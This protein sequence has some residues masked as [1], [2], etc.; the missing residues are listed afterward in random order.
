ME[1]RKK[2]MW[3]STAFRKKCGRFIAYIYVFFI[4]LNKRL[5]VKGKKRLAVSFC[6]CIVAGIIAFSLLGGNETKTAL[7]KSSMDITLTDNHNRVTGGQTG[8]SIELNRS[9]VTGSKKQASDAQTDNKINGVSKKNIDTKKNTDMNTGLRNHVV[10]ANE[11]ED[12]SGK[13]P[14]QVEEQPEMLSPVQALLKNN[15]EKRQ[16][17]TVEAKIRYQ[18]P[19]QPGYDEKQNYDGVQSA[20]DYIKRVV[21]HIDEKTKEEEE[22]QTKQEG[23]SVD[24]N[25]VDDVDEKS[26][27]EGT[28]TPEASSEPVK[29]EKELPSTE[30]S[31]EDSLYDDVTADNR[32]FTVSG[33]RRSS[34]GENV[35]DGDI[36]IKPTGFNGFDR[37]RLGEEGEFVSELAL[38]KEVVGE[39]ITLYFSVR[40]ME[41]LLRL[42][43]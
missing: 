41:S 1:E 21:Y 15:G 5:S 42:V 28:P 39:T 11:K 2:S 12:S 17:E 23:E 20:A 18:Y 9:F 26:E 38:T 27:S 14:N 36:T 3:D 37:V 24:E 10:V 16:D 30:E 33:N 31:K 22:E 6:S 40:L 35:F 13:K 32:Y 7:R 4:I 25:S 8:A 29:E 34:A 43:I 19:T